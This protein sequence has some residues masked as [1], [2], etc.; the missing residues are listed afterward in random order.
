MFG[1]RKCGSLL[2][3]IYALVERSGQRSALLP[4]LTRSSSTSSRQ[5]QDPSLM[6]LF[7]SSSLK[8]YRPRYWARA[9]GRSNCLRCSA[10]ASLNSMAE[11]SLACTLAPR[12][13]QD[14]P[15]MRSAVFSRRWSQQLKLG[16]KIAEEGE[17]FIEEPAPIVDKS[18]EMPM[19]TSESLGWSTSYQKLESEI[20]NLPKTLAKLQKKSRWFSH[21]PLLE[22]SRAM[23]LQSEERRA[24]AAAAKHQRSVAESAHMRS[25]RD[26]C[27]QDEDF[28]G[29]VEIS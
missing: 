14:S 25:L 22:A 27:I 23:A 2:R 15:Q 19:A 16:W 18:S 5:C 17:D 11:Q 29:I 28:H 10:S 3:L 20:L 6:A 1:E 26:D 21:L 9:L 4:S 7:R 8:A 13:Y 12:R 24:K